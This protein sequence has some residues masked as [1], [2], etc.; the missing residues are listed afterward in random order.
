MYSRSISAHEYQLVYT[1]FSLIKIRTSGLS[2][3]NYYSMGDWQ[4]QNVLGMLHSG[5]HVFKTQNH[6]KYIR[7]LETRLNNIPFQH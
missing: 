3:N 6:I 4:I 2:K 1:K 7:F 5:R